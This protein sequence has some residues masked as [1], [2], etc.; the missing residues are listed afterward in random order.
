MKA[1]IATPPWRLVLFLVAVFGALALSASTA[2]AQEETAPPTLEEGVPTPEPTVE[3]DIDPESNTVV[4]IQVDPAIQPIPE[5]EQFNAQVM[6][7]NVD[8]LA[9]FDFTIT[10]DPERIDPVL[11]PEA[12]PEEGATVEGGTPIT[13]SDLGLIL[14]GSE[15][16]EALSCPLHFNRG[17]QV[18]VSCN[19]FAPPVC[20]DGPAGASGSGVLATLPFVSKGGGDTTLVLTGSTLALD[21][22]DPCDP[23]ADFQIIRIPHRRQDSQIELEGGGGGSL[24][25]TTI[26]GIAIGVIA[27]A[28]IAGSAGLIWYRR[29]QSGAGGAS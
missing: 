14:E 8:H 4:L 1:L 24:S 20:L 7:E 5:G 21:D 22:I 13:A 6:V 11:D 9:A 25:S 26:A 16:G 29:R 19:T 2:L 28:A 17:N 3:E 15:R 10:Y 27:V 23:E 12:T 18:T